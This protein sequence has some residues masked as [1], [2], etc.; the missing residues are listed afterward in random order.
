MRSMKTIPKCFMT[1]LLKTSEK[2][3]TLKADRGK[4]AYYIERNNEKDD[5]RLIV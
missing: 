1:K 3:K 4:D 2:K 5:S